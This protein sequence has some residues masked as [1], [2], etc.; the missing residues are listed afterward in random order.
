[1]IKNIVMFCGGVGGARAALALHENFSGD[2]LTFIVN[3]GD[4]FRHFGLEIWPDWD[5]VYYHLSGLHDAGRGWGRADEG[6]RAMEEFQRYGAPDWFHLGDRDLALH[7]F[8]TWMRTEGWGRARVANHLCRQ[9]GLSCNLLPVAETGLQTK[10][11]LADGRTMDFQPWFVQEKGNPVVSEIVT[12][13]TAKVLPE[14][15]GCLSRADLILMAPSNPYLSLGP[16][17]AIKEL[18]EV[19][20]RLNVPK[21]AISPLVGG[22]AVK[23]PL[24]RLIASLSAFE[25]QKAIAEYWAHW[26]D[27][28]LLPE[29]EATT[30]E[31][32][33]LKILAGP[34]L[35]SE[36]DQRA[37]FYQALQRAWNSL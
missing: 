18:A 1:V 27:G 9:V 21:L 34:T 6:T 13:T 19:L 29:D 36:A 14:V 8:R 15:L 12:D 7:V 10:L 26:V 33:P 25:G 20:D 4:D 16:M 23:G 3:S 37:T 11:L 17:L 35:L 24:D 30:L 2:S 32:A 28:L 31:G 22:K 5:T